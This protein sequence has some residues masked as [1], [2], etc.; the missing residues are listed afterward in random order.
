MTNFDLA[1]KSNVHFVAD[2]GA[3]LKAGG[4]KLTSSADSP[5]EPIA[6]IADIAGCRL[7]LESADNSTGY[8]YLN[9][10]VFYAA[11]WEHQAARRC[12]R[13]RTRNI[14]FRTVTFDD[15]RS[16]TPGVSMKAVRDVVLDRVTFRNFVDPKRWH[17]GLPFLAVNTKGSL[18]SPD[19]VYVYF[20]TTLVGN[21]LGSAL[22]VAA[23][24]SHGDANPFEPQWT[25]RARI[26]RYT[27]RDNTVEDGQ[28]LTELVLEDPAEGPVVGPSTVAG[29]CVGGVLY[30]TDRPC[31]APAEAVEDEAGQLHGGQSRR[32]RLPPPLGPGRGAGC[33]A[34][35]HA[36]CVGAIS[37]TAR[38]CRSARYRGPKSVRTTMV[39]ASLCRRA[40]PQCGQATCCARQVETCASIITSCT[41][42]NSSLASANCRPTA[43]PCRT[44][45]SSGST[46]RTTA[47]LWSSLS[48]T[49]CSLT[50][51]SCSPWLR[52]ADRAVG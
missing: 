38:P 22:A 12:V 8:A 31:A 16:A 51:I 3:V 5:W 24:S 19:L 11:E 9:R 40:S 13:D 25:N 20:G 6:D 44:P 26:G 15:A 35:A 42:R 27:V 34:V 29:N 49:T 28:R 37:S 23:F 43:S 10:R 21:R 2:C 7:G 1:G 48:M 45:R 47:E 14:Y 18:R 41:W 30:G 46:S 32:E 39:T 4:H 36:P 17:G 50:S 52:P 33:A